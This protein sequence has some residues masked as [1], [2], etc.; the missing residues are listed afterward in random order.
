MNR[1]KRPGEATVTVTMRLPADLKRRLAEHSARVNMNMTWVVV[2]LIR[3]H[4]P[5]EPR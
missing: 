5:G 3:K 4:L 1:R 2:D